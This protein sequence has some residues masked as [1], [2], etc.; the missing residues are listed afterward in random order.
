[1]MRFEVAAAA[2]AAVLVLTMAVA[3]N[4]G[5]V[6]SSNISGQ[7]TRPRDPIPYYIVE[8]LPA[9]T[10]IGSVPVDAT[11]E[12]RYDQYQ[13]AQLRYGIV[14]QKSLESGVAVQLFDIDEVTGIVRTL[15]QIDRDQLCAA[16]LTC[17][18]QLDVL[19]RPGRQFPSTFIPPPPVVGGEHYVLRVVCLSVC[20]SVRPLSVNTYFA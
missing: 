9:G 3:A 19:V 11:L 17:I 1:M 10:L 20:P 15:T 8:E 14:A 16:R 7:A 2:S 13:M 4:E 5:S 12:R 18:V 6:T